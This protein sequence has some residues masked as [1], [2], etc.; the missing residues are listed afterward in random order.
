MFGRTRVTGRG[1][2]VGFE[3]FREHLRKRRATAHS[4]HKRGSDGNSRFASK[5]AADQ[6]LGKLKELGLKPGAVTPKSG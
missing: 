3:A 1:R 4:R 2:K 5:E 6:A